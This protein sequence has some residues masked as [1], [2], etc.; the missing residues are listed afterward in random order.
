MSLSALP[1]LIPSDIRRCQTAHHLPEVQA[2]AVHF[3]AWRVAKKS[4]RKRA[5]LFVRLSDQ[6][7]FDTYLEGCPSGQS[8]AKSLEMLSEHVDQAN[9]K[10]TKSF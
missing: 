4:Y 10:V 9:G 5:Y 3:S 7:S 1:H 2:G 6:S 8:F